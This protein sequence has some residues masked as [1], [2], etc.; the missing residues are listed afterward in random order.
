MHALR[1]LTLQSHDH[2]HTAGKVS[3][4]R[5]NGAEGKIKTL[6]NKNKKSTLIIIDSK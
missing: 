1:Y 3:P 4:T 6:K 2:E 5:T